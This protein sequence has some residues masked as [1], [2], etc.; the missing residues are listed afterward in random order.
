MSWT[1]RQFVMQ[2]FEEIGYSSYIF[3][4]EPEQLQ[5][6][7]RRLDS[8]MGTWNGK[9]IRIGY[10]LPSSPELSELDTETEVQDSA[11]EAIY[12]NLAIRIAPTVGKTVSTETKKSAKAAYNQLLALMTKPTEMQ[13]PTTLPSGA[14]NKGWTTDKEF[15]APLEE[16]IDTNDSIIEFD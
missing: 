12:L 16:T 15:I 4:L 14:G 2:A 5:S 10:P 3:D 8:M 6:A 7:L 1:K 11:N 9:G 13:L